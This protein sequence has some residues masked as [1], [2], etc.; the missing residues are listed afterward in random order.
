[1]NNYFDKEIELTK[2]FSSVKTIKDFDILIY[3]ADVCNYN[4]RYCFNFFP[5]SN[6]YLDLDLTYEFI[7][8]IRNIIYD[9]RLLNVI[10]VGG[11]PTM[12]NRLIDFCNKL[13]KLTKVSIEIVFGTSIIFIYS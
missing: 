9:D 7:K 2:Q 5:R 8:T 11:E 4:C 13:V 10:I 3:V 12:H 1:M 6:L